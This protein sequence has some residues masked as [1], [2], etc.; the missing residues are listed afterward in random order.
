MPPILGRGHRLFFLEVEVEVE[1]GVPGICQ[2][3]IEM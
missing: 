3:R 1:E 2:C